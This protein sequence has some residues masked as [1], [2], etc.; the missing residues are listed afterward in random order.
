[1]QQRPNKLSVSTAVAMQQRPNK[2]SVSTAVAM[3]QRPDKQLQSMSTTLHNCTTFT[4]QHINKPASIQKTFTAVT[5]IT[6]E[7]VNILQ[8]SHTRSATMIQKFQIALKQF[9]VLTALP[10]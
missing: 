3:Q 7:P 5:V 9:H 8:L 10:L 4:A 1:M 6:V 2:L